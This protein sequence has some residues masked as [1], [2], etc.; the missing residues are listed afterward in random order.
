MANT[1]SAKKQVKV[2]ARRTE[3][4]KQRKS[5]VRSFIRKA[6]EAIANKDAKAADILRTAESELFKA[7]AKGVFK[8]KTA[9]RKISRLNARLN[10]ADE[11]KPATEKAAPAKKPAAKKTTTKAAPKKAAAKTKAE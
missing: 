1:S 7:V 11:A 5:R 6:E 4:N 8:K 10:G 3:R 2:I 9:S